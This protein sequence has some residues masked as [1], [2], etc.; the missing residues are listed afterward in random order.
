MGILRFMV[1]VFNLKNA[2]VLNQLLCLQVSIT[3]LQKNRFN[4]HNPALARGEKKK[5]WKPLTKEA[6]ALPMEEFLNIDN[7]SNDYVVPQVLISINCIQHW[8]FFKILVLRKGVIMLQLTH[9]HPCLL[10]ESLVVQSMDATQNY[11]TWL[12]TVS[13]SLFF[14]PDL[15]EGWQLNPQTQKFRLAQQF[16]RFTQ[17]TGTVLPCKGFWE[18]QY[19][20]EELFFFV[21]NT[22][23][24][25]RVITASVAQWHHFVPPPVILVRIRIIFQRN[26]IA[27]A[28][29]DAPRPPK[30]SLHRMMFYCLF[31]GNW[32]INIFPPRLSL[33]FMTLLFDREKRPQSKTM[34]YD[35]LFHNAD[36]FMRGRVAG[37]LLVFDS[38][39]IWG[40]QST[41]GSIGYDR[42]IRQRDQLELLEEHLIVTSDLARNRMVTY[43]LG[44]W[45]RRRLSKWA[46]QLS[47]RGRSICGQLRLGNYM[48]A[49]TKDTLRRKGNSL[50]DLKKTLEWGIR[51]LL[52]HKS[53]AQAVAEERLECEDKLHYAKLP[54]GVMPQLRQAGV[55]RVSQSMSL[56]VTCS[57]PPRPRGA[58][59]N[60]TSMPCNLA[61]SYGSIDIPFVCD[62]SKMRQNS[63]MTSSYV[64][65]LVGYPLKPH[66]LQC[67]SKKTC[68]TKLHKRMIFR[69]KTSAVFLMGASTISQLFFKDST[70]IICDEYMSGDIHKTPVHTLFIL[71]IPA[72]ISEL[73]LSLSL[74]FMQNF[75]R[76]LGIKHSH[77]VGFWLCFSR[78]DHNCWFLLHYHLS[79]TG[80]HPPNGNFIDTSSIH[81]PSQSLLHLQMSLVHLLVVMSSWGSHMCKAYHVHVTNPILIFCR[82]RDSD[83]LI[84]KPAI[85]HNRLQDLHHRDKD[86]EPNRA[87]ELEK[88]TT[89][90]P[91]LHING[92]CNPPTITSA[93]DGSCHRSKDSLG[94]GGDRPPKS[95][96]PSPNHHPYHTPY[97]S[98]NPKSRCCGMPFC[99]VTNISLTQI[100]LYTTSHVIISIFH[101][102]KSV[103]RQKLHMKVPCIAEV[104]VTAWQV[105]SCSAGSSIQGACNNKN[106]TFNSLGD[107]RRTCMVTS[108]PA[109][110]DII[111]SKN[112]VVP[113]SNNHS[114]AFLNSKISSHLSCFLEEPI[115]P[116]NLSLI[117]I[118]KSSQQINH[119][120]LTSVVGGKSVQVIIYY[121]PHHKGRQCVQIAMLN[122][123]QTWAIH[124]CNLC[125]SIDSSFVDVKTG[126]FN[127]SIKAKYNH[128]LPFLGWLQFVRHITYTGRVITPRFECHTQLN[129]SSPSQLVIKKFDRTQ[130]MKAEV[131]TRKVSLYITP[132][133]SRFPANKSKLV[134][135]L[136]YLTG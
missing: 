85:N 96:S 88:K 32:L 39:I 42:M 57:L 22:H 119:S 10:D 14:L 101:C 131:N 114:L 23:Q 68:K 127:V 63:L 51:K 135:S 125:L 70:G 77:I 104:E 59:R 72:G 93:F 106:I 71:H 79:I 80:F 83:S 61:V 13:L 92:L 86:T 40:A 84:L 38:I 105:S 118:I 41:T 7:F 56:H 112:L 121:S 1:G 78:L 73:H 9:Y 12:I 116:L 5:L 134:F 11:A 21:F 75:K 69:E 74:F 36:L 81:S 89:T 120:L 67:C 35:C 4:C 45:K 115:Q 15:C 43:H 91:A 130:G 47:K 82:F 109:Q 117:L 30:N 98:K 128:C 123:P 20:L 100:C 133:F 124:I 103:G 102:C 2:C 97:P 24:P 65:F 76:L 111:H 16:V 52:L 44:F 108:Q 50:R 46:S 136:L 31:P 33:T 94:P 90:K 6:Q 26:P 28:W 17:N 3:T 60:P 27:S 54:N 25:I 8:C 113:T 87:P 49:M 132:T 99:G 126:N 122:H 18:G 62:F 29:T 37:G 64:S 107:I 48:F 53:R 19:F 58:P 55:C 110:H 129:H 66:P 95:G 34:G